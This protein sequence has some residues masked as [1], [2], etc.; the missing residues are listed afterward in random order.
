[1]LRQ[2][3]A[4]LLAVAGIAPAAPPQPPA[5]PAAVVVR[6]DKV[7]ASLERVPVATVVAAIVEQT[8]AELRGDVT[9][10]RDLTLELRDAPLEEALE[11]ILGEQSFTLTY[12]GDGRLKRIVLGGPVPASPGPSA[13]AK[14]PAP[15][16]P[17]AEVVD[18]ARRVVEFVQ[19]DPT[20]PVGGRL[21]KALGT[22]TTTF[23]QVL[24]AALKHEDAHVRADARRATVKA[25]AADP[26][27]RTALATTVDSMTDAAIV[28]ALRAAAGA[29]AERLATALAR[30]GR[31]P[32]LARRMQ[33]ALSQLRAPAGG[34]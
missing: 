31:S 19:G 16:A 20:V 10:G 9:P 11:R 1:M 14:P 4:L 7:T 21:A 22:D 27:V 23:T 30:H 17:N 33:R 18:A 12:E 28:N 6:T 26:E 34:S 29:D 3:A 5:A 32:V 8:G 15:V 24:G 25:V 2:A 13:A